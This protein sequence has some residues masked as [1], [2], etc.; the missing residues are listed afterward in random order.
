MVSNKKTILRGW[1]LAVTYAAVT[2]VSVA[3][4]KNSGLHARDLQDDCTTDPFLWTIHQTSNTD[5][6]MS[7]TTTTK[8]PLTDDSVV[9]FAVGSIHLSRYNA[10]PATNG[11]VAWNSLVA[12]LQD[13]CAVFGEVDL[14]SRENR[15]E[16][17]LCTTRENPNVATLQDIPDPMMKGQIRAVLENVTLAYGSST[18]ADA[19]LQN[20]NV[21]AGLE[22]LYY[23]SSPPEVKDDYFNFF[24]DNTD[25]LALP[26]SMETDLL[27]LGRP[28]GSL[29]TIEEGCDM[30]Q[31]LLPDQ[32]DFVAR[33]ETDYGPKFTA[34]LSHNQETQSYQPWIDAY[35]CGNE[36]RMNR[37]LSIQ[38]VT[39]LAVPMDI[40][41]PFI[42]GKTQKTLILMYICFYELLLIFSL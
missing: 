41:D 29:E 20:L 38:N 40:M 1:F 33:Y 3:T 25:A 35:Q 8:A 13:S 23:F 31:A 24:L 9:G 19:L 4:A 15:R 39:E 30:I 27:E 17:A 21:L 37:L 16:I 6:A 34:W 36:E 18:S 42:L 14:T 26:P 2:P 10:L 12:A 11:G 7:S 5:T 32:T 22:L 28:S